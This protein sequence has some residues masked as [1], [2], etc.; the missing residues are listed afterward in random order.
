[1]KKFVCLLITLCVVLVFTSSR[2]TISNDSRVG[3]KASNFSIGNEENVVE[4]EQYRGKFVV[5]NMWTSADA[6][7]RLENI[8]LNKIARNNP[9]IVH[10]GVNFDRSKALFREVVSL[11]SLAVSSQFFCEIQD[12]PSFEKRWGSI[13]KPCTFL[14]NG[15]G[16]IVAVNPTIEEI[17]TAIK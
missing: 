1:M 6:V 10:M 9:Q 17:E 7:T 8:E 14:I 3:T 13:D 16:V 12:R 11:D 4:L 5:L 15:K 2:T